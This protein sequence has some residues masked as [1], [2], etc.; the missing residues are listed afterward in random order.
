MSPEYLPLIIATYPPETGINREVD[1]KG[2][3]T[4]KE[5]GLRGQAERIEQRLQVLLDECPAVAELPAQPPEIVFQVSE[6]AD[7]AAQF[8][9]H[10]PDGGRQMEP[11]KPPPAQHSQTA[12][13]YE[14]D[15]QDMDDHHQIGKDS[16]RHNVLRQRVS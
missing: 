13:D 10:P 3:Q 8:D 9:G 5:L 11:R 4:E 2:R 16:I 7:P 1:E 15:E 14:E 12:E 6:G